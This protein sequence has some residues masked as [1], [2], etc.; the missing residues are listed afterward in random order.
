[1][2]QCLVLNYNNELD[3]SYTQEPRPG[4]Q[5]SITKTLARLS[6]GFWNPLND[7]IILCCVC[8]LPSKQMM[9]KSHPLYTMISQLS[10]VKIFFYSHTYITTVP[11]TV[12]LVCVHAHKGAICNH[13]KSFT[14]ECPYIQ[15]ECGSCSDRMEFMLHCTVY[16]IETE[17]RLRRI[18][19]CVA[20]SVLLWWQP[21]PDALC[22][23]VVCP[24]LLMQYLQKQTSTWRQWWTDSNIKSGQACM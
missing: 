23:W 3:S 17:V 13:L 5:V 9:K 16:Q 8:Q 15:G 10:R 11:V 7:G 2:A 24:I 20:T 1:M 6:N 14:F 12:L 22:F 19:F 18:W 4:P 21:W